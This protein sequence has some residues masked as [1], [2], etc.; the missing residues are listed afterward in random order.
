MS[1]CPTAGLH[2]NPPEQ[3]PLVPR[4]PAPA[5]PARVHH[6]T[7]RQTHRGAGALMAAHT[8]TGVGVANTQAGSP[9]CVHPAPGLGR[10]RP[11]AAG[12]VSSWVSSGTPGRRPST[13]MTWVRAPRS[14]RAWSGLN[15]EPRGHA[16]RAQ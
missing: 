6:K 15:T 3:R 10:G 13:S 4:A 12:G 14:C 9:A 16:G 1:H 5:R 2:P 11:Q 8:G 7:L